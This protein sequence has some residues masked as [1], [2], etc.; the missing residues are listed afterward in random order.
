MF[1][2]AF[3]LVDEDCAAFGWFDWAGC[4]AVV[5]AFPVFGVCCAWLLAGAGLLVCA[6]LF[7][8]AGLLVCA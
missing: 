8:G 7:A 3:T 4:C 2:D 5:F 1:T 6:W